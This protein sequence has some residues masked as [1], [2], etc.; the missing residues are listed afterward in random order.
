MHFVASTFRTKPHKMCGI[1]RFTSTL[2]YGDVL[3]HCDFSGL[4]HVMWRRLAN[5]KEY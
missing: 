2:H 1:C 5:T 3:L 4:Q